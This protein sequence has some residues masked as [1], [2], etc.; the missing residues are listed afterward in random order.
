MQDEEIIPLL[1]T[2]RRPTFVS[3]DRGFF[4]KS[5]AGERYCLVYCN[6]RVEE[7]ALF[8]RR[9]LRHPQFKTWAQRQGRVLRV[10]PSG[11]S[12]WQI[13]VPRMNRYGWND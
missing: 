12:V 2:M 7:V 5:F 8:T 13:R 11:V 6:V 4:E 3:R 10:A 9:L 1:R